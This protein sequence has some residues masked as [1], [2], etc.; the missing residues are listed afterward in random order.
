ML[1]SVIKDRKK[2]TDLTRDHVTRE[3]VC[4]LPRQQKKHFFPFFVALV[5]HIQI[6]LSHYAL[7]ITTVTV[8]DK[9][10]DL[11]MLCVYIDYDFKANTR[12]VFY[13]WIAQAFDFLQSVPRL[14]GEYGLP[15]S[16]ATPFSWFKY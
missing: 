6:R 4:V 12:N 2:H 14:T 15:P 10:F 1:F 7:S 3:F 16:A 11:N 13:T 9:Y 5:A 8:L